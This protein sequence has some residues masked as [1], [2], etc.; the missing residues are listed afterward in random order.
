MSGK[1]IFAVPKDRQIVVVRLAQGAALTGEIFMESIAE[2]LS[3]HQKI[4]SFIENSNT[5]FPIK[6][7]PEGNTEFINKNMVQFFEVSLPEDPETSYFAHLLMQTIPVMVFLNDGSSV[8]GELMAEVPQEKARLSDC[9]N[10]NEKFLPVK[11][12][13]RMCYI[14]KHALQKVVHAVKE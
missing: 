14:N 10:L 1:T 4:T 3:I 9:L 2:G 8:S 12:V 7:S 5:F 11:S 6:L 13:G